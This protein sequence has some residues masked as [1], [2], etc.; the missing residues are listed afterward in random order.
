MLITLEKLNFKTSKKSSIQL[1]KSLDNVFRFFAL[2]FIR[3]YQLVLSPMLGGACRFHPTCSCYG[4]E[5]FKN[6]DLKTAFSLT[7]KRIIKCRPLG[8]SGYDPVPEKN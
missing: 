7:L 8:P 5:A 6:H 3:S 1:S 2:F 4:A